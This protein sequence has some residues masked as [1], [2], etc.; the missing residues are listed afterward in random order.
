MDCH[1]VEYWA[2]GVEVLRWVSVCAVSFPER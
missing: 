1:G 2:Q